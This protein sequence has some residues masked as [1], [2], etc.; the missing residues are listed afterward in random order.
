MK[1]FL[2]VYVDY[3]N[4]EFKHKFDAEDEKEVKVQIDDY[5]GWGNVKINSITEIPTEGVK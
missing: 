1:K 3:A 4:Q 5:H 2:V